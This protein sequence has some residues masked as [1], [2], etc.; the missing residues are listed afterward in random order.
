MKHLT[1]LG[2]QAWTGIPR[3]FAELGP[4]ASLGIGIAALLS[5]SDRYYALDVTHR[6][7]TEGNLAILED[8]L[9]LFRSRE[10]NP[11]AGWPDFSV[12][13]D[14]NRFPRH[15]LSDRLLAE[16]LLPERV[17]AIRHALKHPGAPADGIVVE[18]MVPWSDDKVLQRESVDLALS[19]SVLEHVVDLELTYRALNRWLKPGGLM[20][21]QIDFTSHGL[22]G[23]WNGHRACSELVWKL[24]VG[25]QLY[26]INRAPY[27]VHRSLAL[28][29][30]FELVRDMRNFRSDGISRDSLSR[31]WSGI[32]DEDLNCSGAFLQARKSCVPAAGN[33]RQKHHKQREA[34]AG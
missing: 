11:I 21:H 10:G 8:L 4:G 7:N 1:L 17:K 34:I 6:A 14:E 19:H 25:R 28:E 22:S 13:L 29:N 26:L 23:K 24:V 12:Y 2:E 16:S 30:G 27:S 18:Y 9:K 32:S 5:G 3:T 31:R 33:V 20:S 15:L